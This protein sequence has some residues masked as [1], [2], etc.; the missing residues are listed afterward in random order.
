MNVSTDSTGF[1]IAN[2]PIPSHNA[3]CRVGDGIN[4]YSEKQERYEFGRRFG[5]GY[6]VR[7]FRRSVGCR[8]FGAGR[9]PGHSNG[10]NYGLFRNRLR[11]DGYFQP[12]QSIGCYRPD[13]GRGCNYRYLGRRVLYG[14]QGI[15]YS[16]EP[17]LTNFGRGATL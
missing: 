12:R 5:R 6:R 16:L 11:P 9:Y 3:D 8:C 15:N 1:Y 14:P 4:G 10:W 17:N 13:S 7:D 2:F